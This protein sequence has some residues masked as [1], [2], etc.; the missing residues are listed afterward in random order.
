MLLPVGDGV[1]KEL[2][3]SYT[4]FD[5]LLYDL[6]ENR[7]SGYL[8]ISFWGF[9]GLLVLDA[10][11]MV[12]GTTSERE[13]YL[14][15]EQAVLRIL[16]K[17][18]DPD[19]VIEIISLSNEI[20]ITLGFALQ[21][22]LHEDNDVLQKA[23]IKDI[24]HFVGAEGITG[25]LDIEFHAQKG[26]GTLYF[27]EGQPVD[28]IIRTPSGKVAGGQPVIAKI[29]EISEKIH[30][31]VRLYYT[32]GQPKIIEEYAFLLPWAHQRYMDFINDVIRV[33]NESIKQGVVRRKSFLD[34]LEELKNQLA[35]EYPFFQPENDTL[36]FQN[37]QFVLKKIL[38]HKSFLL[39]FTE[40]VRQ[41]MRR[42]PDRRLKKLDQEKILNA[43]LEL[44]EHYGI[45]QQQFNVPSFVYR[46][47]EERA[48]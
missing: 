14:M 25:Y 5:R 45:P 4:Q 30:P 7:F 34:H 18:Q 36:G 31:D 37:G 12:Q 46:V 22:V 40:L 20:A 11:R 32:S 44:Q 8:R 13:I 26:N 39:G 1:Q 16:T 35:E 2:N 42:V 33:F 10:G 15:G 28:A 29:L 3:T 43:L 24:V 27:L 17:V 21:A 41:I 9:E 38:H 48:L 23:T 47:F 19:G 6:F